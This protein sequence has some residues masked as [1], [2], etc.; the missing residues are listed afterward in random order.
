M[1]VVKKLLRII[2]F[3]IPFLYIVYYVGNYIN[4]IKPD[5]IQ[6]QLLINEVVAD[7]ISGLRDEKG[8]YT[9]WIE[10]YNSTQSTIDLNG[11]SIGKKK[12]GS[13]AFEF[14][15]YLLE[16]GSYLV[17]YADSKNYIDNNFIHLNFSLGK[18]GDTLYLFS[19][20]EEIVDTLRYSK[21]DKDASF[22]RRYFNNEESGTFAYAT[23]GTNN[24]DTFIK[25]FK[26]NDIGKVNFSQRGGNYQNELEIELMCEDGNA[27]ILYTMDGSEPMPENAYIYK[28]PISVK[29]TE[30]KENQYVT[31]RC[32]PSTSQNVGFSNYLYEYGTNNVYKGTVIRA[33]LYKDG[34]LSEKISTETFFINAKYTLPVVSISADPMELFDNENGIYVCGSTYYAASKLNIDNGSL[35]NYYI[36]SDINAHMEIWDKGMQKSVFA[37]D[38]K[39]S[40]GGAFSKMYNQEKAFNIDI[41]GNNIELPLFGNDT[42]DKYSYSSFSLKSTGGGEAIVNSYQKH[43]LNNMLLPLNIGTKIEDFC[44][45]FVDGEYWGIY[46]IIE[47]KTE[48][49]YKEHYSVED[50]EYFS[51]GVTYSNLAFGEELN[52]LARQIE[53]SDFTEQSQY[54]W[55]QSRIDIDNFI[56]FIA[57]DIYVG[58]WDCVVTFDHNLM[59]WR[60][61]SKNS[62]NPYEDGR[63][64][65]TPIDMD[66]TLFS[67]G[68]SVTV[69]DTLVNQEFDKI[70]DTRLSGILFQKLWKRPDFRNR[71]AE[72]IFDLSDTVFSSESIEYHYNSHYK[73]LAP[74]M[75]ENLK[76]LELLPNRYMEQIL[77]QLGDI[78]EPI[79]NLT[80]KEWQNNMLVMKSR[81]YKQKEILEAGLAQ[82]TSLEVDRWKKVEAD[83]SRDFFSLFSKG[84]GKATIAENDKYVW[85]IGESS[86]MN[87]VCTGD[88]LSEEGIC[89]KIECAMLQSEQTVNI[90]LNG[91]L[92][93]QKVFIT[94]ENSI[95]IPKY[96][97]ED[98][99]GNLKLEYVDAV[100]PKEMGINEE[101]TILA[102]RIY[103][104]SFEK[105]SDN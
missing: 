82:Y 46:S 40:I 54:E 81:L 77:S 68:C 37:S 96:L 28:G 75:E 22:G 7:N 41:K 78:R 30:G 93:Q 32:I 20:T 76:R 9:D 36:D 51:A 8:A 52:T 55:I 31:Q 67:D 18:S 60:S 3:I 24:P 19:E 87:F 2:I 84:F 1:N 90:Y 99:Y 88:V 95:Y 23:P 72:K 97:L 74:E 70:K 34:I 26:I 63:L 13:K 35:G 58:N 89:I 86:E 85:T 91:E 42:G 50:I 4:S 59:I 6:S 10:L 101:E 33:R 100:S 43:L 62:D 80:Y 16:P 5:S 45:V 12:S 17:L 11:Y 61:K 103:K 102:L 15:T 21:L 56:E 83:G 57:S 64:R 47:P 79:Q 94:G 92:L 104:I 14:G 53:Q 69:L 71:V 65:W 39:L 44:V 25:E 66:S 27:V 73:S 49:Y 98:G 105:A 38:I 29:S 48:E